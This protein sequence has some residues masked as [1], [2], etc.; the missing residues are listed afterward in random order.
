MTSN[1]IAFAVHKENQRHNRFSEREGKRHNL[2]TERIGESNV[3][4]G[5]ANLNEMF[6]HNYASEGT[7]S[8]QCGAHHAPALHAKHEAP[9][10]EMAQDKGLPLHGG[11]H[12]DL[13]TALLDGRYTTTGKLGLRVLVGG[14]NLSNLLDEGAPNTW[15]HVLRTGDIEG[16]RRVEEL[17][18]CRC[19]TSLP[20]GMREARGV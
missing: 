6:R 7:C 1:Q 13:V 9:A 3:A 15:V 2:R 14:G 19:E 17:L 4:L 11:N 12:T 16:I 18:Q 8:C 10:S 5:Y 20:P